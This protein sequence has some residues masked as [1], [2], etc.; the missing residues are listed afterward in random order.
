MP[1]TF[2][3]SQTFLHL[4]SSRGSIEPPKLTKNETLQHSGL[5]PDYRKSHFRG[6]QFYKF[7]SRGGCPR[8]L[9]RVR[10]RWSISPTP[11]LK[12]CIRPSQ[13]LHLKDFYFL[14]H[15]YI[16]LQLWPMTM[17]YVAFKKSSDRAS[18]FVSRRVSWPRTAFLIILYLILHAV[19]VGTNFRICLGSISFLFNWLCFHV[20]FTQATYL[21]NAVFHSF[22]NSFA[23]HRT[24]YDGTYSQI[25]FQ[26]FG[27][28]VWEDFFYLCY[29]VFVL[30]NSNIL[31]VFTRPWLC[32][33]NC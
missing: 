21:I 10:P 22:R 20:I 14:M 23:T 1:I 7:S 19:F 26:H 13:S 15:H 30:G 33:I 28:L 12:S 32:A 17:Y 27:L 24:D 4:R 5:T 16:C 11:S 29:C 8:D 6:P 3:V 9:Y 31:T 25:Y 18:S 2:K